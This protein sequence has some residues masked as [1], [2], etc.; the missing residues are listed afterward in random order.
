MIINSNLLSYDRDLR[1]FVTEMSIL[2]EAGSYPFTRLYD[3]VVD[4]GIII[5]SYKTN[6]IAKFILFKE[7]LVDGYVKSWILNPTIETVKKYPN[8]KG[9]SVVIINDE[10]I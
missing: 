2:Y 6:Q 1:H 10:I 7:E 8:L 3:D 5:E 9:T 4:E